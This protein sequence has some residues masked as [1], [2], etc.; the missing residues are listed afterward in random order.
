MPQTLAFAVRTLSVTPEA[1]GAQRGLGARRAEG[2]SCRVFG[3][4]PSERP[5]YESRGRL[6]ATCSSSSC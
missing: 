4:A 1:S 6:M 2:E 3:N 5:C